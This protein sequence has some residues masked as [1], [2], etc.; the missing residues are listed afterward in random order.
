MHRASLILLLAIWTG[1]ALP[2]QAL[3]HAITMS[4]ATIS[5]NETETE[6]DAS[7]ASHDAAMAH[8][9]RGHDCCPES[10][11][12]DGPDAVTQQTGC[13]GICSVGVNVLTAAHPVIH[14]FPPLNAFG[15]G[16]PAGAPLPPHTSNP[17]RPPA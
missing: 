11:A 10:R 9:E 7:V 16:I 12:P 5:T 13:H 6:A 15:A 17:L 8:H 4:L 3:A 14:G 1:I 2:A